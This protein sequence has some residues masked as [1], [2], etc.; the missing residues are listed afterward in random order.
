MNKLRTLTVLMLAVVALAATA[1]ARKPKPAKPEDDFFP[2]RV[3]DFWTYRNNESGGYTLKVLKEEPQEGGAVRYLVER[4][5]E[6][7][8]HDTF[9]KVPGWVLFHGE[10]YPEQEGLK[11]DYDPPRQ[12]LPNPLVAGQKWE[13]AGK[14]PTQTEHHENNRVVGFE[15]VT[16]P[17]G[18]F[19]AMKVTSEISGGSSM[20]RTTWYAPGVGLIKSATEAGQIKYGFELT[21]YSF[22]K[23]AK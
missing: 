17:A 8:I 23:K 13:W 22:K 10:N 18:K 4:R 7:I 21:D 14:D 11:M 1:T 20:V 2:L 12:Y 6:V 3:G 19:R 15:N 16:V 9:S 5:S